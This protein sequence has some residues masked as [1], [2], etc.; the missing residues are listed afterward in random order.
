MSA[1]PVFVGIDV[2]KASLEVAV[3][4]PAARWAV[5][6]TDAAVVTLVARLTAL[7]P[8]LI[9]LEAVG[10]LEAPPVGT[11]AAAGLP[12]VVV[13]PRQVRD[14]AK[15]TGRLA[16]TDTLDAAVLAHFADAVRPPAPSPPRCRHPGPGCP[17]GPVAGNS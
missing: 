7:A 2:A 8:A 1:S 10:G 12:G 11:L 15:A 3:H 4:Q 16:K 17:G 5:E 14:F 13:N 6:C 9:V